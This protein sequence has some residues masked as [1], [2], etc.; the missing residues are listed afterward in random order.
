[1]SKI[2]YA[3]TYNVL[4]LIVYQTLNKHTA[5]VLP[6]NT[7]QVARGAV[8]V[9]QE[10]FINVLASVPK[11]SDANRLGTYVSTELK[12]NYFTRSIVGASNSISEHILNV[13]HLYVQ[14][15]FGKRLPYNKKTHVDLDKFECGF[16]DLIKDLEKIHGNSFKF[17]LTYFGA[18]SSYSTPWLDIQSVLLR[19]LDMADHELTVFIPQYLNKEHSFFKEISQSNHI[20]IPRYLKDC[21]Q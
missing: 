19:C 11:V 16:K 13:S 7:A 18:E 17:G 2:V 5:L 21:S 12:T 3:S 6:H 4:D 14:T 20:L 8:K 9:I 10:N 1:M 15:S